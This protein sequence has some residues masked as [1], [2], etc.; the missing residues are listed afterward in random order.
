MSFTTD[1]YL[2][3][4]AEERGKLSRLVMGGAAWMIGGALGVSSIGLAVWA[5]EKPALI[6]LVNIF[7]KLVTGIL[8]LVGAWVGAVIAFY[9]A[10]DNFESA[11]AQA[12]KAFG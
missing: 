1:D 8:A 10:R 5:F 7:D 4:L 6:Q 3:K 2:K 11:S 9:F 12:Q